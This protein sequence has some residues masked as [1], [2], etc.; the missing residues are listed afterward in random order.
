MKSVRDEHGVFADVIYEEST[1]QRERRKIEWE[2]AVPF[3]RFK[4]FL[5]T[6]NGTCSHIV[7]AVSLGRLDLARIGIE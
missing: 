2:K 5:G 4:E 7:G 3:I 6:K 1:P